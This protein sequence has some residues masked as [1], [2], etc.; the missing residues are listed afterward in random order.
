M[1]LPAQTLQMLWGEEWGGAPPFLLLHMAPLSCGPPDLLVFKTSL[2]DPG[3]QAAAKA[4]EPNCYE[5]HMTHT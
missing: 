1:E 2:Q 3:G 5:P 4:R